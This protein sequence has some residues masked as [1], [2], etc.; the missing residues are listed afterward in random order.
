MTRGAFLCRPLVCGEVVHDITLRITTTL[1]EN[2]QQHHSETV[3]MHLTR[4]EGAVSS[5]PTA[6]GDELQIQAGV[7]VKGA[8]LR[9]KR[10]NLRTWRKSACNIKTLSNPRTF[11]RAPAVLPTA[12][13]Q[14]LKLPSLKLTI[15]CSFNRTFL[16]ACTRGCCYH[17]EQL[18]LSR[19]SSQKLSV[20]TAVNI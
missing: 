11:D 1:T 14:D 2:L 10:G 5:R 18:G 17:T 12:E 19:L 4:P 6:P 15:S 13:L 20:H 7:L 9:I 8:E 16:S 3:L